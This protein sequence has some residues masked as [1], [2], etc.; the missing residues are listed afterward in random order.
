VLLAAVVIGL[1]VGALSYLNG[2]PPAGA[3]LAGMLS[4]GGSVPVLHHLIR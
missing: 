4:T 2:T 1:A 3:V